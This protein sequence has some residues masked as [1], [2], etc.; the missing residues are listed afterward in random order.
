MYYEDFIFEKEIL[1]VESK[2][3]ILKSRFV[4]SKVKLELIVKLLNFWGS[5]FIV[6]E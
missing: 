5:F 4:G 2:L 1:K 3:K 6:V